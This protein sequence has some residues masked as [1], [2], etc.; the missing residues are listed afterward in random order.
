MGASNFF[1]KLFSKPKPGE[2]PLPHPKAPEPLREFVYLD[3]VSLQSLLASQKGAVTDQISSESTEATE[4]E[5][6]TNL[7]AV[8]PLV[9][10]SELGSR[11]LSQSA[12]SKQVSRKATVQSLF[13]EL[14]ELSKLRLISTVGPTDEVSPLNSLDGLENV[15]TKSTVLEVGKLTRGALVEMRV[16][17][18]ADPIFTL[19]TLITEFSE[20]MGE[21]PEI[22]SGTDGLEGFDQAGPVNIILEKFLTGLIPIR[23]RA[24]DHVVISHNSKDFIVHVD[25][26]KNLNIETRPLDVVG[27]TDEALYWR[28]IRR[29]LF[30]D[31]A[32]TVLARVGRDGTHK[33]WNPV[34]LSQIFKGIAPNIVDDIGVA[35]LTAMGTAQKGKEGP[36]QS[37]VSLENALNYYGGELLKQNGSDNENLNLFVQAN[38]MNLKGRWKTVSD[39]NAAFDEMKKRLSTK[40]TVSI[41]PSDDLS[42]RKSARNRADLSMFPTKDRVEIEE[43]ADDEGYSVDLPNPLNSI[44]LIDVEF[45]AIYW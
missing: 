27:V 23:C 11:L 13:R 20:M 16:V 42:L 35:S 17:L 32:F 30:S 14:H 10:E 33:S 21:A 39:Q 5:L 24:L 38:A 36:Y 2:A 12:N 28:D 15:E 41:I 3:E 9:V 45:I 34:K 31:A 18:T 25:V 44:D 7:K 19:K 6:N 37:E 1:R 4:A 40:M 43:S 22:F 8:V 29:I 26:V